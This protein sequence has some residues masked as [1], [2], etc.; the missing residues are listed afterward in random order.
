MNKLLPNRG[1][2]FELDIVRGLAVI[3]MI[4]V[5]VVITFAND[6]ASETAFAQVSDLF[7]GVPAAPVFMFLLGVGVVYSRKSDAISLFK[8]GVILLFTAYG[9]N[10]LRSVLPGVI[11][12]ILH[13]QGES[14]LSFTMQ[15]YYS[16]FSIDILQF[17]GIAFFFF[18]FLKQIKAQMIHVVFIML[19]FIALNQFISPTSMEINYL[20][21]P[22]VGLFLSGGGYEGLSYFPFVTWIAYPLA[23][24]LFASLLIQ[25]D[26]KVRFYRRISY[27][28]ALVF[29]LY[30]LGVLL[31]RWPT[32]YESDIAYYAHSGLLNIVYLSFILMWI[33]AFFW[34]SPLIKG[35]MKQILETLSSQ[36][37]N[38]YFIHWVY[39]G[40]LTIV[41]ERESLDIAGVIFISLIM[42]IGSYYSALWYTHVI[43]AKRRG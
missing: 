30:G 18:A 43:K 35:A 28:S 19:F 29:G 42:I 39:I 12:M 5:H 15:M 27:F 10:I 24:Y 36:V 32:G 14:E 1:R 4:V 13:H 21:A 23:G 22:I 25:T 31:L 37:S 3:F 41:L 11:T 38:I 6:A 34:L 9:L 8:R 20:I 16:L 2:Q 17:S 26:D 7:G 40:F 33:S